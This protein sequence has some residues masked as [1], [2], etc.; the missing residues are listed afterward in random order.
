MQGGAGDDFELFMYICAVFSSGR[1]IV[2]VAMVPVQLLGTD[3][4]SQCGTAR[5]SAGS[6]YI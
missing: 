3:G 6:R 4:I 1:S 5:S 2:P